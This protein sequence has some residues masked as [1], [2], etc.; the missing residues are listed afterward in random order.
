MKDLT[1]LAVITPFALL[2][3]VVLVLGI[4]PACTYHIIITR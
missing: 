3:A 4:I 1:F 2:Y